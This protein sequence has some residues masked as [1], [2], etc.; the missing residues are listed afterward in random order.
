[1][2]AIDFFLRIL[3]VVAAIGSLFLPN[4]IALR[5]FC[6]SFFAVGLWSILFPPGILGWARV[7]SILFP[8]RILGWARA[9]HR[10]LDP[11]DRSLWWV[12]RFIGALFI[13]FSLLA[14]G[15]S[16]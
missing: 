11:S 6:A 13:A 10:E 14:I 5:L 15:L 4:I 12:P 16:R 8:P 7:W 1:M 3:T 2:R 9:G